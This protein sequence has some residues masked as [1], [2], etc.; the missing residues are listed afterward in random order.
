MR[1][2]LDLL[3]NSSLQQVSSNTALGNKGKWTV[4]NEPIDQDHVIRIRVWFTTWNPKAL[5][6]LM[7]GN[8]YLARHYRYIIGF[9]FQN[10]PTKQQLMI[11]ILETET[12]SLRGFESFF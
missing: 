8:T 4:M 9:N 7:D 1:W 2:H 3:D 10:V 5:L 6:H 12:W 11:P